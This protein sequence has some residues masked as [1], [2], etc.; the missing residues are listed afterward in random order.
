MKLMGQ[1]RNIFP[2]LPQSVSAATAALTSKRQ[3]VRAAHTT[4]FPFF[5]RAADNEVAAEA[6]MR[7]MLRRSQ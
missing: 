6:H 7:S 5:L 2:L 3:A 4:S 1:L